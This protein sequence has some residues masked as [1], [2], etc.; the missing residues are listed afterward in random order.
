MMG[1]APSGWVVVE[2]ARDHPEGSVL[3]GQGKSDFER[4]L[5]FRDFSDR[6]NRATSFHDLKPTHIIDGF[7][8]PGERAVDG[9]F[10]TVG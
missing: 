7:G 9:F 10:L 1:P 8:G 3:F 5:P 2:T 4:Y 6:V